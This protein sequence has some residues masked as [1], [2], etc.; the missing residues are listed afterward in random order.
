MTKN[1]EYLGVGRWRNLELDVSLYN[2]L[3]RRLS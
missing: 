1:V 2:R 3:Q